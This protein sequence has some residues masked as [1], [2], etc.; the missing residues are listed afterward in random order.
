MA[1]DPKTGLT[2]PSDKPSRRPTDGAYSLNV[3]L[4]KQ[5]EEIASLRRQLAW[6]SA[7]LEATRNA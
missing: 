2:I 1:R 3:R 7:L 5:A 4:R 6:A